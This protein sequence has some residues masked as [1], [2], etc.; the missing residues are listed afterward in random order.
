MPDP[1]LE[2]GDDAAASAPVDSLLEANAAF[3]AAFEQRDLDA[4]SD[5]WAH[6]D[7]VVCTHPGWTTLRG[8][9]AVGASWFALFQGDRPMQFILTEVHGTVAGD[10]GWVALD[11]NL[12][13]GSQA[14]TVAAVN[15]FRRVDGHWRLVVHHGSGIATG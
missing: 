5:V 13:A 4:M 12:I 10:A 3:Y 6:G 2:P 15:V 7:D 11:E 1:D 9:A 14:Q 8:W